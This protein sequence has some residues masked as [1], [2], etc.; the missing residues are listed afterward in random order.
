MPPVYTSDWFSSNIPIWTELLIPRFAGRSNLRMLEIGSYE[1]RS[2]NWIAENLLTRENCNLICVDPFTGSMEHNISGDALLDRFLSNIEGVECIE[3]CHSTSNNYFAL[4]DDRTRPFD[5]IYIDG[6]HTAED[7]LQDGLNAWRVLK[8]GGVL[9]FD[10]F[11]WDL[12]EQERFL[13]RA[14]IHAFCEVYRTQFRA[15]H[16]GH[17]FI[18]EKALHDDAPRVRAKYRG[19]PLDPSTSR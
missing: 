1:G 17:Q 2:A 3:V 9:I 19:G 14:G 11:A 8:N 4:V 5:L 12:Y 16:A 6:S 18:L 10:D 15:L 13:P 7:V